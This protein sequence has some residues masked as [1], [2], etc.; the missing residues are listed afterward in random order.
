[1]G[2]DNHVLALVG[3]G[4]SALAAAA[5][6]VLLHGAARLYTSKRR[7]DQGLVLDAWFLTFSTCPGLAYS[8]FE[9]RGGSMPLAFVAYLVAVWIGLRIVAKGKS[10][11]SA[12]NLLVMPLSGIHAVGDRLLRELKRR[13]GYNGLVNLLGTADTALRGYEPGDLFNFLAR[14]GWTGVVDSTAT[15]TARL[16]SLGSVPDGDGRFRVN[17]FH[18]SASM[19]GATLAG[20]AKRSDAVLVDVRGLSATAADWQI[21]FEQLPDQVPLDRVVFLA[22]RATDTESIVERFERHWETLAEESP[23]RHTERSI[24]RFLYVESQGSRELDALLL[25]LF[26]AAAEIA[27]SQPPETAGLNLGVQPAA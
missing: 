24:A 14:R 7:S 17:S 16:D 2:F 22:N 25:L 4:I 13:W 1:M 18:C 6:A 26:D 3:V 19:W 9:G 15:L 5:G 8:T 12:A 27:P 11:R 10:D 20:L 23:N 21:E